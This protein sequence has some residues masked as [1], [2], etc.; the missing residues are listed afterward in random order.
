M[1]GLSVHGD[2]LELTSL[3]GMFGPFCS[4]IGEKMQWE[5]R[6]WLPQASLGWSDARL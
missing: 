3:R 1:A 5:S 2:L 4:L 6:L